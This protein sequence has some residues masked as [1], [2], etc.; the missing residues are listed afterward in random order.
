MADLVT[1]QMHHMRDVMR[2]HWGARY[3]AKVTEWQSAISNVA[4]DQHVQPLQAAI[5][6]AKAADGNDFAVIAAL[7]AYVEMVEP[8]DDVKSLGVAA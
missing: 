7:A 3:G 1:A 8:S 5:Q 4:E 2:A 6:L